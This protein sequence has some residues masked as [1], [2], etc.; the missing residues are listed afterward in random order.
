MRIGLF[1]NRDIY[2]HAALN[3]LIPKLS[4]HDLG[5]F[6]SQRVGSAS[7]PRDPRLVALAQIETDFATAPGLSFEALASMSHCREIAVADI[8][9]KDLN[10]LRAFD[11]D[12]LISIRF[13]QIF[14]AEAIAQPRTGIINL[15]SGLL[16]EYKGVMASFWSL[17]N[18]ESHLGT[19][20][21]WVTDSKIDSGQIISQR[22]QPV[23][24]DLTYSEQV[25]ALYT[26]GVAQLLEAIGNI[27]QLASQP[28]T[29]LA[30][31]HYF[32]FPESKDLDAFEQAGWMLF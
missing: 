13:G 20:L 28:K 24:E 16:P 5:M 21:H 18:S 11:A 25:L 14:K 26:P 1:Y 7:K 15:H 30:K 2:A 31:G 17:L 22:A 6:Y 9:G 8:N 4:D 12:L 27:E 19:T 10:V 29:D 23:R 3:Q 32:S